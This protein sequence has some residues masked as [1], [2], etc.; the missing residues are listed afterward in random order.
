MRYIQKSEKL[1]LILVVAASAI[2]EKYG[3][4]VNLIETDGFNVN[5]KL[6]VLIEGE[7][8]ETMAK[9]TGL[10][11][12]EFSSSLIKYKPDFTLIVADRFEMLASAIASAYN[13]IPIVHV[14]GGEVSGSIDESIRHAITKLAHLHFPA[15]ELAR[16]R[17]IQMGEREEFIFNYGCPRIDTVKKILNKSPDMKNIN[18]YIRNRGVGKIFDLDHDFLLVSQHPVTT[19]Y[20][21]GKDQIN[22]TLKAVKEISD[23][24]N[25]PVFLLWPNADAGSDDIAKAIRT[26]RE[27]GHDKNF[28][29]LKN[30]P[31]EYYIRLMDITLCLIGNSSSGIREGSFI[32]TPVVNIGTRQDNRARGKNV[33]DANYEYENI[34]KSIEKQIEHG[35]YESEYIYGNGDAG[36]NIVK[37]LE[38]IEVGVQKNFITRKYE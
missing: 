22:N 33:I 6:Y 32:G 24:R 12:I 2:L 4:V 28:H 9:S 37:I 26:F 25:L 8:P 29:F 36:K 20:G 17:I 21:H 16:Q 5:E 18:E 1:D 14:Q 3:E 10:A 11:I 13:N 23:E 19:E 27:H 31:F 38:T 30:L 15:N 34:K 7:T 35:K